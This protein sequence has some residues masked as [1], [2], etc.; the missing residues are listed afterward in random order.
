MMATMS[1]AHR[2]WHWNAGVPMGTPG[3]P[4]D[5]CHPIEPFCWECG[6]DGCPECEP[7]ASASAPV[8]PA[9]I[10]HVAKFH[11]AAWAKNFAK[12][13]QEPGWKATNVTYKAGGI[14]EFDAPTSHEYDSAAQNEWQQWCD[15]AETVGYYSSP[16]NPGQL[17]GRRAIPCY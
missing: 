1:D 5:A 8:A 15:Y 6:D 9:T 3:C 4:Q 13:I 7:E 10:H 12:R 17:D 16:S 14:V 2:E 11:R